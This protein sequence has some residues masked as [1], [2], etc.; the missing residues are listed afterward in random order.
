[1]FAL[2]KTLPSATPHW[3]PHRFVNARLELEETEDE[4]TE[5]EETEEEETEEEM[6]EEAFATQSSSFYTGTPVYDE[7]FGYNFDPRL[8]RIAPANEGGVGQEAVPVLDTVVSPVENLC[9]RLPMPTVASPVESLNVGRPGGADGPPP[10]EGMDPQSLDATCCGPYVGHFELRQTREN[11]GLNQAQRARYG[12]SPGEGESLQPDEERISGTQATQ[13]GPVPVSDPL[14]TADL[15]DQGFISMSAVPSVFVGVYTDPITG[16]EFDAYESGMP[17]PDTDH[18]E[19][20]SAPGRNVKLAHLQGGWSDTTP[21]PTKVEV[22]E[23]DFHMQYDRSINTFGTYD[24]SYYLEVIEQN[25]R[26]SRDDHHVDSDGPIV[27]GT[28]ANTMGNQGDVKIRF[29]PYITPTNRGKWA[30]TTFRSG[31][32]AA[33]EG[34]GGGDMRLDYTYTTIPYERAESNRVDGGGAESGGA[35]TGFMNQ[36]GGAEGF[37]HHP[38]Q[39]STTEHRIPN[40]GPAGPGGAE[41]SG[42]YGDV[43]AP[44][45]NSGT[46]DVG[47]YGVGPVTGDHEAAALQNQIVAAPHSLAGLEAVDEAAF[48][49]TQYAHDGAKLMNQRVENVTSKSGAMNGHHTWGSAGV[50]GHATQ[51]DGGARTAMDKTKRQQLLK[52]QGAF[53]TALGHMNAQPLQA[54]Q[55]RFSDKSGHLVDFMMPG[56]TLGGTESLVN[57]AQ[58]RGAS[59]NLDT[60]RQAEYY[61]QFGVNGVAANAPDGTVVFGTYRQGMEHLSERPLGSVVENHNASASMALGFREMRENVG[62]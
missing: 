24:P 48:G 43:A 1:M 47:L 59:T 19:T 36:Y 44:M 25:N 4:E 40:M 5:E 37:D 57:G 61:N 13:H 23:D 17:P 11:L 49:A 34:A 52:V 29:T 55:T 31:I 10:G 6:E 27:T 56:G 21:R 18:T 53:D 45:G 50:T 2:H 12:R 33:N 38:T 46:Q 16:E 28:P 30:E 8:R 60:K 9:N 26:F 42:V 35:Y 41:A 62:M 54:K 22:L 39:Q 32:D 7:D 3:D 58:V 15:Y 20:I 51:L 14:Y